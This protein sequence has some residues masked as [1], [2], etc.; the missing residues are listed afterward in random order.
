MNRAFLKKWAPAETLPIF[1]IVGIA[2][3]GASYYLYRLSQGP[4]VVWDRHGDWRPWDKITHDTNQKL[5]TV[6]PEFWEKRRQF[7]KDQ[8]AKA[9]R[10]VDQI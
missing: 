3:G 2:V 6:N 4:E 7:V 8:K 10:V 5:I 1:G 9:E